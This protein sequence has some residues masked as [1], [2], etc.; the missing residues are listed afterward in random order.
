ML[1]VWVTMVDQITQWVVM[2]LILEVT[3]L[4]EKCQV[5][6]VYLKILVIEVT[7]EIEVIHTD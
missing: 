2:S 3:L 4:L 5:T 1:A 7:A 6:M